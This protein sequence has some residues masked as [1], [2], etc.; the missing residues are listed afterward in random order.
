MRYNFLVEYKLQD[1]YMGAYIWLIYWIW[2]ACGLVCMLT[3][4]VLLWLKWCNGDKIMFIHDP[5]VIF[6]YLK[7]SEMCC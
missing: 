7:K 3:M 6:F 4:A 5:E 2:F 1:K